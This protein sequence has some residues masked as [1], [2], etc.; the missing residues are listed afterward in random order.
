MGIIKQ[1]IL[2]GFSG[3]VGN[4]VGASWKGIDYIRSLPSSVRNPRTPRQVKQ[5]TKFSLV[6][7]FLTSMTPFIRIGFKNYTGQHSAV[8]AAMSY[9]LQNGV[10][11]E[12]DNFELDYPNLLVSRGELFSTTLALATVDG[13]NITVEWETIIANDAKEKDEVYVVLFNKSKGVS[14]YNSERI[15]RM[16]GETNFDIPALWD[17]DTVECYVAFKALD[18]KAMSN[19]KYAGNVEIPTE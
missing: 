17:G 6:Q 10:K 9:N 12:D 4:V 5:R 13:N 16:A 1:G 2:G 19:S 7:G 8:N 3:K 18:G 14:I 11:G 15:Y